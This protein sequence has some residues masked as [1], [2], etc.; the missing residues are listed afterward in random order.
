MAEYVPE[1][2]TSVSSCE[3]WPWSPLPPLEEEEDVL[4]PYWDILHEELFRDETAFR[5]V[6]VDLEQ[7]TRDFWHNQHLLLRDW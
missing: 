7:Q 6:C 4:V 5:E 3:T 1:S 2:P